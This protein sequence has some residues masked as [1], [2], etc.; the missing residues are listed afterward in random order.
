M[1]EMT[2]PS[3]HRIRNYKLRIVYST[4]IFYFF[5]LNVFNHMLKVITAAAIHIQGQ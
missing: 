1:N 5:N 4:Q 2:L 3:R